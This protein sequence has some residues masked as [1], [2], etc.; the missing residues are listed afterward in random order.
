LG[1]TSYVS[2]Q[3]GLGNPDLA[4]L[5]TDP[6]SE[7]MV[8]VQGTYQLRIEGLVFE[9]DSD[10]N[11]ELVMLGQVYGIAGTDY[12]RRDLV[13][14]LLWGMPFALAIG[15]FGALLTTTASM[16]IAAAGVWFGG[17]VDALIQRITEA[18]MILPILA[19]AVLF[20]AIF[21]VSLWTILA[22]IVILNVFSSPTKAFR[23]AFLQIK[24]EPY[25]EA[26]QAY[27]ASDVRIVMRY[28]LPR[29]IPVLIPALILSVPTFVFLEA[30]LAVLGLGDPVLPTWGK[31][32]YDAWGNAAVYN[33]YYYWMLEPAILLTLTGIGFSLVGFSLDRI[34]NPK[35]RGL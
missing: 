24:E 32:I 8:P 7:S 2:D 10:I 14:P 9:D 25:I 19:L 21:N 1:D 3:I 4:A 20:Y 22:I 5:F 17:W 31:I 34:F 33:G 16:V 6:T 30:T 23:A 28:L 35:L 15:L 12:M 11:A 29:L 18:N 27:G 13:I 26:A